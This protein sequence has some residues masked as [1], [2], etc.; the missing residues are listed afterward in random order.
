MRTAALL[1][2]AALA[3]APVA[4]PATTPGRVPLPRPIGAVP[5][6]AAA[7]PD[8]PDR[9]KHSILPGPADDIEDVEVL[10][11]PDGAPATVTM[12][13]HL[14]L[15]GTGQFIVWERSSAQDV[16]ALEDTI[17]PVLRREAVVWQGFV[18]GRKTLAARLTLD[19]AVEAGLVPV[20]V[21]LSWQ[22]AG[23]IG[24]GGE[25]P[26]PGTLVVRLSNR[27]ARPLTLPVGTA[28][29][30]DMAGPLDKL[31]AYA[32]SRD[33]FAPPAAGR[34][35]PVDIPG[36]QTG[37][38]DVTMTAPL[39]VTGTILAGGATGDGPGT[40]PYPGGVAVDGVLQADA[41]F[42]LQVPAAAPLRLD[43]TV[44]PT[45]DPRLLIPPLG[46]T[47]AEWARRSPTPTEIEEAFTTLMENAAA[48]A[49]DDEYA[50]YLGHHAPGKVRTTYH[51][52]VAPPSVVQV[53]AKPLRPKPLPIALASVALL[54]IVGN[55]VALHRRL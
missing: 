15:T 21:T 36:T 44:A 17:A 39:R 25:L 40:S 24:P 13:Q 11:G 42:T 26:G 43:L 53:A 23:A 3:G 1:V 22:G 16:E 6:V 33:T 29:P 32:R 51:L 45:V 2:S 31:L 50:P 34:G 37:T 47:W 19:P 5:V 35:L 54:G 4:A 49:R 10:V 41:E 18:S 14:R 55:V 7:F 48:A 38:R 46:H 52:A 20:A 28:A 9:L 30:A 8:R 12:T 27:T